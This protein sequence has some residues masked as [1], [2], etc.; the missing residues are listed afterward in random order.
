M[1][2]LHTIKL[3]GQG[4]YGKV[5][6]VKN[7][8]NNKEYA[9]KKIKLLYGRENIGNLTELQ[10]LSY[11]KCDYLIK[12]H[13]SYL[14]NNQLCIITDFYKKGDLLNI[15]KKKNKKC[16]IL[17]KDIFGKYFWIYV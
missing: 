6:H 9:L 2:K 10:I 4:S 15:I 5:Y 13:Y 17:M 12:Y 7:L 1:E 11:N 14:E 3:I 8:K 16:K